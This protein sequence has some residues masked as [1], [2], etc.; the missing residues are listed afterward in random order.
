MTTYVQKTIQWL[1]AFAILWQGG[2][3]ASS[4][5][6]EKPGVLDA[7]TFARI[8]RAE[9][10]FTGKVTKVFPGAVAYTDPPGFSDDLEFGEVTVLRGTKPA[11]MLFARSVTQNNPPEYPKE[12]NWLV[13]ADRFGDHWSISYI[14]PAEVKALT[15]ARQAVSLPIGWAL[16]NDRP[17][18]PWAILGDKAWPRGSDPGKGPVCSKTSRPALF[19]GEGIRLTAEQVLPEKRHEFK[20]P[21]GNGQFKLTVTNHSEKPVAVPALLTDGKAILWAD[22]LVVLSLT[23]GSGPHLLPTA[24][25]SHVAKAVSL[26]PGASVSTI[27]DVLFL[28]GV[29]WARGGSRM[30]FRICLGEK[31]VNNFFYY[32]SD[33]HDPLRDAALK[34]VQ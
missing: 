16:E 13:A 32:A 8:N 28:K 20:N 7:K 29:R 34:S 10:V 17:V 11:K 33:F 26:E 27:I 31:S 1:T 2:M 23:D 25:K 18:S 21:Y 6:Q 30:Y 5:A 14:V 3:A 15:R 22:S 12:T 24:G 4:S 19:A 9:L